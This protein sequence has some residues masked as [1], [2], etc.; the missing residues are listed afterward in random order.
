MIYVTG[1]VLFESDHQRFLRK[2]TINAIYSTENGKSS[3]EE[4]SQKHALAVCEEFRRHSG[5]PFDCKDLIFK[6]TAS[7]MDV[8][9]FGER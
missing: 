2:L 5:V 3:V 4:I 8:L 6:S 7:C 9:A 1:L